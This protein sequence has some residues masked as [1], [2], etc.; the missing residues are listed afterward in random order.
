MEN[1]VWRNV[2]PLTKVGAGTSVFLLWPCSTPPPQPMEDTQLVS[3]SSPP[4]SFQTEGG[5]GERE[6]KRRE[7]RKGKGRGEEKR[8]GEE[9]EAER[10]G[11]EME[12][13]DREKWGR[14]RKRDQ[15]ERSRE[16]KRRKRRGSFVFKGIT[17]KPTQVSQPELP[18]RGSWGEETGHHAKKLGF[19]S[20]LH[21]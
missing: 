5:R 7:G 16:R 8:R 12:M 14:A 10:T 2:T 18:P 15:K 21:H 3:E 1:G 9:T 20:H 17:C 19:Q 13:R 4:P 6:R 11:R